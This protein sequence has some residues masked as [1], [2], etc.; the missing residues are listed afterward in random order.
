MSITS[1]AVTPKPRVV[2]E[3]R[4]RARPDEIWDLWTTKE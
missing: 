4:Y 1:S 2:I 3:R